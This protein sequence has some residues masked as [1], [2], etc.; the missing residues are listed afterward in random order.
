MTIVS[1]KVSAESKP[2]SNTCQGEKHQ[3]TIYQKRTI[4]QKL[5]IVQE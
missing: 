4:Y 5:T 3:L 1:M 2:Y